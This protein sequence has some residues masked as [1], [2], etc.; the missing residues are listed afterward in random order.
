M[1]KPSKNSQGDLFKDI[2]THLCGRKQ[3]LRESP[4]SWHNVFYKEVVSRI[5]ESLFSELYHE[6]M[7]RPNACI[8]ILIGMMILK[9]GNGWSDEQLYTE[10]RFNIMVMRS[11]GLYN[12]DDDVPAESTY[13]EFRRLLGEYYEDHQRD[14][15][16]EVFI[17]ITTDQ[18]AIHGVSGKKI[19]LDS[20]LINSNIAK[21]NRLHL[22]VEAVRKYVSGKPLNEMRTHMDASSYEILEALQTKST[23]NL[24]Y[25][26]NA[27]QKK[28]MLVSMGQI[29]GVLLEHGKGSVEESYVL[30]KRIY[31][32]QYEQKDND[33]N[34][35]SPGGSDQKVV[36]KQPKDI[37][38]SS[39]QSIHDPD[40]AYRTKGQG[41]SKQT[42]TGYHSNVTE[43]CD[44]QEDVHLILD[45]EVV[46]ANVSEDAFLIKTVDTC[47]QILEQAHDEGQKIEEVITDGGY[48]SIANREEMLKEQR[49]QWSIAK[50]KGRSLSYQMEKDEQGNLEVFDRQSGEHLEVHYSERA[51]K[52][53]IHTVG[54][55]KRYMTEE[56]ID[57]YIQHQR[58]QEQVNQESYNLRATAES[59]IHQC[60]HRL[61]KRNK[62]IYR[63]LV[64]CHWYVLSRALWVNVVRITEKIGRNT[65]IFFHWL[66]RCIMNT[67][68]A[69][70]KLTF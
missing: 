32:E 63:G 52:H 38:S 39:V 18:V 25:P 57:N 3:K 9:E 40:A 5:D 31:E 19:R 58:I 14:L 69:N 36:L 24:T 45:V 23:S 7:G 59:T 4:H 35:D 13:Y 1:F 47:Q 62:I 42:V 29:I 12:M 8:R 28:E 56:Q 54:G 46:K 30:L 43:S 33:E 26:L 49:P 60:F 27:H 53:V 68:I 70:H 61:K 6:R 50:M 11:L 41:A 22:I 37:P 15:M 16:K 2:S 66:L 64:K 20:K 65:L 34:D 67:P 55:N 21:S 48:D 10:C 51:Q 17:K 44:P